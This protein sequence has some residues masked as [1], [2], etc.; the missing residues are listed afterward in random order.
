LVQYSINIDATLAQLQVQLVELLTNIGV[1]IDDS[2]NRIVEKL[3]QSNEHLLRIRENTGEVNDI[4][5]DVYD[6]LLHAIQT[7]PLPI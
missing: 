5:N 1:A 4:L 7:V 3:E 6:P 2:A